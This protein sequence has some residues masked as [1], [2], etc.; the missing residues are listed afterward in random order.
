MRTLGIV[1]VIVAVAAFVYGGIGY[2]RERTVL[3][4][5]GVKATATEHK[6]IPIPPIAGAIALAGGIALIM[7]EKRRA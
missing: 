7:M 4:I 5:G 3:D 6:S 1:L 2:N